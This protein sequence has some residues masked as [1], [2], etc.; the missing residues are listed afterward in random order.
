MA[1][2]FKD[3][4]DKDKDKD[5]EVEIRREEDMSLEDILYGHGHDESNEE[6]LGRVQGMRGMRA[7]REKAKM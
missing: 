3:G 2:L 1:S 4:N 6:M 7:I 5:K